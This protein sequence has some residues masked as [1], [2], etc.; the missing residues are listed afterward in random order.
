MTN[1]STGVLLTNIGTPS[2][3]TPAAV[4]TYLKKFLSD[5]RVVEVPRVIWWPIL[6]GII[7]PFRS[8]RSA[9]LYQ[10]IWTEQGSPLLIHSQNIANK[11]QNRLQL[12]VELGM[13]YSEPSIPYALQSLQTKNIQKIIVMPLYPQYSATSTAATLD[14]VAATFKKWRNIPDIAT[15]NDYSSNPGYITAVCQS[16]RSTWQSQGQ[17]HLFF[18]FHGI[19]Q[20][21]VDHGDPYADRC[22]HTARL[23]AEELKL[24]PKDWSLAFQSRLG[25]AKWLT[26]YTNEL[27]AELPKQGVTDIQVV[28]PGFA[29]DCLETLEEIAIRGKEIFMHAGGKPFYYIPALNDCEEHIT[30]LANIIKSRS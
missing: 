22:H 15:I 24:S 1:N 8:K 13:Q 5:P 2:A 6:Q 30:A 18:S 29:A 4:R 14:A 23:I 20:R 26:P 7:L 25:R 10:K 9:E 11:L 12:P 3:P 19:P 27:L 17:K 16:I 28:C 21:Y